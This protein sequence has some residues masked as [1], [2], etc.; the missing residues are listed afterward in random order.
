VVGQGVVGFPVE[1]Q[2]LMGEAY[3]REEAE[4]E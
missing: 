1:V 4:V 2:N 3:C